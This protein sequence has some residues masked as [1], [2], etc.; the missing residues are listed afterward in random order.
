MPTFLWRIAAHDAEPAQNRCML[1]LEPSFP[2]VWRTDSD[3]QFGSSRRVTLHDPTPWQLALLARLEAGMTESELDGFLR[4]TRVPA[5]AVRSFVSRLRPAL[6]APAPSP[7]PVALVLAPG[8]RPEAES[9]LLRRLGQDRAIVD[10]PA[11]GMIA[12]VL[13]HYEVDPAVSARLMR[14]DITHLPV[15]LSPEQAEIGPLVVPGS[16]ACTTCLAAHRRDRD[17]AWPMVAS[18][19]MSR[20]CPPLDHL[21]V[22]EAAIV[23]AQLVSCDDAPTDRMVTLRPGSARRSW[24]VPAVHPD[25]ACRSPEGNGTPP[26]AISPALRPTTT[27]GYARPA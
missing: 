18:Q 14:E 22:A 23:T 12:V 24:R 1:R 15:V 27:T 19:L 17:P 2:P 26:A 8:A 13:A 4:T 20:P 9:E 3:L 21:L 16:G 5:P 10:E 25:C 7:P 6:M 11:R